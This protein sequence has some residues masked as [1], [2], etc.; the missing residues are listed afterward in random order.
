MER[1]ERFTEDVIHK[2]TEIYRDNPDIEEE[3]L[4]I[5]LKNEMGLKGVPEDS[6]VY[7]EWKLDPETLHQL[8]IKISE[9]VILLEDSSR[10]LAGRKRTI[11]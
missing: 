3:E 5:R 10:R 4:I 6:K 8:L 11:K 9:I 2:A 7:D 1:T